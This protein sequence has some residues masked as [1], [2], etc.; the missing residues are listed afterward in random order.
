MGFNCGIIG[1]PNVGKSTLFNAITS[2]GAA[3]SNFAFCT[4][5]PNVGRVDV[6][7]E[8]IE[9]LSEFVKPER[10]VHTQMEFVDIAGLVAGASKGEGLGNRFLSHIRNVDAIAHVVRCFA[11]GDIMHVIGAVDPIRDIEV[12]ESE[13]MLADLEGVEKKI[14]SLRKTAKAGK[15]EDAEF[16]AKLELIADGLQ[17]G[18]MASETGGF[19]IQKD[20][21]LLTA[22]PLMFVANIGDPSEED[23]PLVQKVR[24]YAQKRGAGF[25]TICAQ[26]EAEIAELPPADR[27]AYRAE[28][29]L[30]SSSLDNMIRE[31]YKLLNLITYFTA[32]VKEVRAW[33]VNRGAKAPEAAGV[34][35]TD[36]IKHFI[37][38]EVIAY[39][40]YVACG[41]EA[42]A[43]EKGKMRVEGKE[44]VVCDG[45]VIYFRVSA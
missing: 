17:R 18:I 42:G 4:V 10:V 9:K 29:G 45:D 24:E 1:L 16:L 21:P 14:L 19:A 13:L 6:P 30:K 2:A 44:Y 23:G 15:K 25:L 22:K 12:I 26:V 7:D 34:I 32:G 20:M 37:R 28:L 39:N 31:G 5:D 38:A 27:A 40:D 3:A 36:F 8:R 33:T 11:S 41:G 43:K 35:H